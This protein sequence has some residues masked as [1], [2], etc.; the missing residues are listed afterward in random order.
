MK[1]LAN[2]KSA[3][4]RILVAEKK[5]LA[6]KSKKSEIKTYIKNFETALDAGK[7]DEAKKLIKLIDKKMKQAASKNIIHENRA[8]RTISKLTKKLNKAI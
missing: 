2:I 8:A 5:T 7:V 4:K 3:K 1:L 6:N